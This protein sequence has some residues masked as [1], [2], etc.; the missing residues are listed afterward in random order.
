MRLILLGLFAFNILTAQAQNIRTFINYGVHFA[1]SKQKSNFEIYLGE[2]LQLSKVVPL[3]ITASLAYSLKNLKNSE[4]T[5]G[6]IHN[7]QLFKLNDNL[8][9][10]N[11]NTPVGFE[12]FYKNISVGANHDVFSLGIKN[13]IDLSKVDIDGVSE[14]KKQPFSNIFAGRKRNNLNSRVY[15]NYTLNDSFSFLLGIINHKTI[16]NFTEITNNTNYIGL[17]DS[18]IFFGF[19]FNLEK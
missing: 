11:I 14:I 16:I 7:A 12:L 10:S 2:T 3:R 15:L 4:W 13:N 1:P 6:N 5:A 19:R 17:K 9:V 18:S 8:L